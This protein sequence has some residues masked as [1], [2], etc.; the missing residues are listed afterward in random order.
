MTCIIMIIKDAQLREEI[1]ELPASSNLLH[2]REQSCAPESHAISQQ[3]D[4]YTGWWK[5][6]AQEWKQA[7]LGAEAQIAD[8]HLQVHDLEKKLQLEYKN[9][10]MFE[11]YSHDQDTLIQDYAKEAELAEE[12]IKTLTERVE[13]Q[14]RELCRLSSHHRDAEMQQ[15]EELRRLEQQYLHVQAVLETAE[16]NLLEKEN[17]LR[18]LQQQHNDEMEAASNKHMLALQHRTEELEEM[19]QLTM[20]AAHEETQ[21]LK[22]RWDEAEA[23]KS[24]L[25]EELRLSQERFRDIAF[26]DTVGQEPEFLDQS[27]CESKHYESRFQ[28]CAGGEGPNGKGDGECPESSERSNDSLQPKVDDSGVTSLSVHEQCT[29]DGYSCMKG[30]DL[31]ENIFAGGFSSSRTIS[32]QATPCPHHLVVVTSSRTSPLTL[33]EEL[34]Q[35]MDGKGEYLSTIASIRIAPS[36]QAGL[37]LEEGVKDGPTMDEASLGQRTPSPSTPFMDDVSSTESFSSAVVAVDLGILGDEMDKVIGDSM[38][39]STDGMKS[40]E[41][42]PITTKTALSLLASTTPRQTEGNNNTPALINYTESTLKT[43]PEHCA[44]PPQT[45]AMATTQLIDLILEMLLLVQRIVFLAAG[46]TLSTSAIMPSVDIDT[47]NSPSVTLFFAE[48]L[49]IFAQACMELRLIEG[50]WTAVDAEQSDLKKAS[51]LTH[52]IHYKLELLDKYSQAVNDCHRA[53]VHPPTRSQIVVDAA[54]N[55]QA[56]CRRQGAM[57]FAYAILLYAVP[58]L[59]AILLVRFSDP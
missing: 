15:A 28:C 11:Q 8:L 4:E 29:D 12:R 9:Q 24:L 45:T 17:Q 42:T 22:Q 38:E 16:R 51:P 5:T 47:A 2:F 21:L 33:H 10:Q 25:E 6:E 56:K 20:R 35:I 26:L 46:V 50:A 58:L 39:V 52:T 19:L 3:D 27:R 34:L 32:L 31:D 18:Q 54:A 30:F 49:K 1:Q 37:S 53:A 23:A 55:P 14:Q 36:L 13:Q 43:P 44:Y 48:L 59:S 7:S 57:A 40:G 41:T